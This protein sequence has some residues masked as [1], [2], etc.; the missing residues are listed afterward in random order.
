M[1]QKLLTVKQNELNASKQSSADD[2]K[3]L[4]K[5]FPYVKSILN[6]SSR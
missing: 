4:T 3:N 1:L 5:E 2:Y 6:K